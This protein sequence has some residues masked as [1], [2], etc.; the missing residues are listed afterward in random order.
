[1]KLM[2]VAAEWRWPETVVCQ[3]HMQDDGQ[4]R[5][6]SR[7]I[8]VSLFFVCDVCGSVFLCE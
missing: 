3:V 8:K 6:L 2:I 7:L 4:N 1:M 5:E